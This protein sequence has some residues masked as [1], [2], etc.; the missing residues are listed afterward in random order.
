MGDVATAFNYFGDRGSLKKFS[1]VAPMLEGVVSNISFSFGVAVDHEPTTLLDLTTAQFTTD[2]ASWDEAEWD[3]EHWADAEGSAITQRR[4]ATNKIGR[5]ISLRIK[6]S[7]STQPISFVSA[8]Y[9][10]LPGGPI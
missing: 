2:L 9:H 8:N 1:S 5:A 4:K 10:I 3:Q 6:I 7:S